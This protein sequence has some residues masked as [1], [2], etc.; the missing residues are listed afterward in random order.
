MFPHRMLY[1][2]QLSDIQCVSFP[3]VENVLLTIN[4]L[5]GLV[6][7]VYKP[8]C[9]EMFTGQTDRIEVITYFMA[10]VSSQEQ[11]IGHAMI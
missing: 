3:S 8:F 9:H 7:Y 4:S 1:L 5:S 6:R 10:D 11:R 2:F